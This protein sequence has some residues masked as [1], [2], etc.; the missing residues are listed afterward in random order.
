MSTSDSRPLKSS[1][2]SD[3]AIAKIHSEGS[4]LEEKGAFGISTWMEDRYKEAL[5]QCEMH[6]YDD[7]TRL[8]KLAHTLGSQFLL[9]EYVIS[10]PDN[11]HLLIITV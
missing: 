1:N 8:V 11:K 6:Y 4:E 2:P 5:T 7:G 3:S 9:N 10:N